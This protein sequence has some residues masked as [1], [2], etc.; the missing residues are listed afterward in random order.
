[1]NLQQLCMKLYLNGRPYNDY[2]DDVLNFK[3]GKAE[4]GHMNHSRKFPAALCPHVNNVVKT[5]LQGFMSSKLAQTGHRPPLAL[6][7]DKATY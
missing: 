7:A 1:M 5:R 3:Q 2:E 4:V 6:S